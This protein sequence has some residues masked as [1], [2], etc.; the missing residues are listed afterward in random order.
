MRLQPWYDY[1]TGVELKANDDDDDDDDDDESGSFLSITG[2]PIPAHSSDIVQVLI[3]CATMFQIKSQI[4]YLF[5]TEGPE[6][7]TA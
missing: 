2:R 7:R 1:T 6:E 5:T 3:R 4:T